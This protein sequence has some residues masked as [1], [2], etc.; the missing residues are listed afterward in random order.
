MPP[1]NNNRQLLRLLAFFGSLL[2]AADEGKAGQ[3]AKRP[4]DKANIVLNGVVAEFAVSPVAFTHATKL[5]VAIKLTNGT[6]KPVKFRYSCCIE[7]HIELYDSNGKYVFW[8]QGAPIPECPYQEIEIKAGATVERKESF[9]FGTFYSVE[10][11]DYTMA[12]KYDLRLIKGR[13]AG[14]DPWVSWSKARL[15]VAVK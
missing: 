1:T 11:G 13:E 8:K 14:K 3:I 12:F 5:Q 7:E 2:A 9:H 15:K 6:E 4:V 10:P